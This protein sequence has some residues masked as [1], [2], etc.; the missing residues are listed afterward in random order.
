MRGER[1]SRGHGATAGTAGGAAQVAGVQEVQRTGDERYLIVGKG[2]LRAEAAAA[3]VN[4]GGRLYGLDVEAPSL[5]E[6]YSRYFQEVSH[7][8]NA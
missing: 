3:V 1:P 7:G 4:A 6:I 5:D 8:A 2:D